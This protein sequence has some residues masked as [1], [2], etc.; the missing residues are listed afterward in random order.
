MSTRSLALSLALAAVLGCGGGPE[1]RH[2][3]PPQDGNVVLDRGVVPLEHHLRLRIDP[4]AERLSGSIRIPAHVYLET[5]TIRLHSEGLSI[6]RATVIVKTRTLQAQVIQGEN[7]GLSLFVGEMLRAGPVE[8]GL[9]FSGPLTEVP[10]GIYRVQDGNP[11]EWYVYSQF[12]PLEA[13]RA[14]PCFDQPDH[15]APWHVTVEAPKGLRA[16]ANA[17]EASAESVESGAFIAHRFRPTPA[18]PSYLLAFAVGPLEAAE[19]S[20]SL[21]LSTPTRILTPRGKAH[22]ATFALNETARALKVIEAY[23]D[24]RYPYDKLDLVAVPNFSAGAM[25][26]PGLIT[27]RERLL[28]LPSAPSIGERQATLSVIAHELAHI[29]FGDLVTLSWWDDLWLNEAFATWMAGRVVD[30]LEPKWEVDAGQAQSAGG[31]MAADSTPSQRAIRQPITHG[32][33][34]YNA[35]DGM[36]YGKGAAVIGMMESF[37]GADVFRAGMLAYMAK[38]AHRNVETSDLYAAVSGAAQRDVAPMFSSFVDQTGAPSVDV[39]WTCDGPAA[40]ARLTLKQT[41]YVPQDVELSPAAWQIPVCVRVATEAAPE[42]QRQCFV[43]DAPER[44]FSL[45]APGCPTWLHPNAD[46][47]GYYRWSLAPEALN[48]LTTTQRARLTTR[49]RAALPGHITALFDAGAMDASAW[50]EQ[51][52]RLGDDP[53]RLVVSAVAGALRRVYGVTGERPHAALAALSTR[54]IAPHLNRMGLKPRYDEPEADRLLRGT[55]VGTHF[56]LTEDPAILAFAREVARQFIADPDGVDTETLGMYLSLAA[57]RGDDALHTALLD[58]LSKATLPQHRDVTI[59]ALGAFRAPTLLER[60]LALTTST[61]LRA[62]DIRTLIGAA[63]G[64]PETRAVAWGFVTEQYGALVARLGEKSAPSLPWYGAWFCEATDRERVATFFAEPGRA[65]SGTARNLKLALE[66]VDRCIQGRA[67]H[68]QALLSWLDAQA[69]SEQ[70]MP[71][72]APASA[73]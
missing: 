17:P 5:D 30:Q 25:E 2:A 71:T 67:R 6:S 27:F 68:G 29:W 24:Q 33:D 42:P 20:A 1:V 7:G 12:E 14:F 69:L 32:G 46:E 61:Q 31:L 56:D 64:T 39:A 62:Q 50:A 10:E 38:H 53:H 48:A 34:V 72:P 70:E 57:S 52:V 44:T 40:P 63:G 47:R 11:A 22:L 73:P 51:M 21:G 37:L 26:N 41:R 35:F 58:R 54:L 9:E 4:S 60:S 65:P 43:L 8:I 3:P 36:T 13:R 45:L 16:F 19:A 55:L 49:E 18:L 15:K 28:L 66:S 23:F 59:R